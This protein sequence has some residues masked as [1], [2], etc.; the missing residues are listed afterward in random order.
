MCLPVV[1][2]SQ[3]ATLAKLYC[4]KYFLAFSKASSSEGIGTSHPLSSSF[5]L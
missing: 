3:A 1:V 2:E 4:F 5:T